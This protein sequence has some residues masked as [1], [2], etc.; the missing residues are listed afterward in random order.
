[1]PKNAMAARDFDRLDRRDPSSHT[2]GMA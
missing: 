2:F 1:V